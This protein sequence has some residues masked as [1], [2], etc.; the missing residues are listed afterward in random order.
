MHFFMVAVNPFYASMLSPRIAVL[1]T[2]VIS[3][4]EAS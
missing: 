1:L 4:C 3:V 2:P